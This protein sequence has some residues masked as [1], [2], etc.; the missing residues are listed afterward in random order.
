MKTY[1]I[2]C[3][4]HQTGS[5]SM[6]RKA[7]NPEVALRDSHCDFSGFWEKKRSK[8]K[9]NKRRTV[10]VGAYK[11]HIPKNTVSYVVYTEYIETWITEVLKENSHLVLCGGGNYITDIFF[12]SNNQ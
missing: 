7:P 12:N 8:D 9:R 6:L 5:H 10:R 11:I 1:L 3:H 2:E 4:G